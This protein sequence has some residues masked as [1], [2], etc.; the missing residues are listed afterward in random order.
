MGSSRSLGLAWAL[1]AAISV[2]FHLL[3]GHQ[4]YH[5]NHESFNVQQ[6]MPGLWSIYG[7]K[8][9]QTIPQNSKNEVCFFVGL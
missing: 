1:T 3:R 6:A 7:R 5:P 4:I 8:T 9:H 2:Q